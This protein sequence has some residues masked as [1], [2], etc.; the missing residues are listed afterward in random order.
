MIGRMHRG[1]KYLG[2]HF[3]SHPSILER[4]VSAAQLD[5]DDLVVEIGPGHGLLTKLLSGRVNKVIAIELDEKLYEKLQS[6][7]PEYT[8]IELVRGDALLYPYEILPDFKVVANIPYYITTPL[9]FR[10][11]EIGTKR[12]I[13]NKE[14]S[15]GHLHQAEHSRKILKSL[16]LTIQK[17]VAERIVAEPGGKDYGVLSIMVQYYAEPKMQFIIPKEAFRPVPKVDSA[18]IYMKILEKPSVDVSDEDLFFSII[19]T[20]FSQRRKMLSNTL[21]PMKKDCIEWLHQ[22][23]IDPKRRPETLCPED[24]ARLANTY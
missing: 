13:H 1:K 18:L 17:E 8:N 10:F 3:L 15:K 19:K 12:G 16:T 14:L 21:K 23:G 11:L 5:P 20:A 6:K 24:F 22:A 9:I 7:F 4:I 2:Q